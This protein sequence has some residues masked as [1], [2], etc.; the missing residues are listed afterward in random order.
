MKTLRTGQ[1]HRLSVIRQA[2]SHPG[3]L[4]YSGVQD[5]GWCGQSLACKM[6][7]QN[8]ELAKTPGH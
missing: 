7:L 5:T 3:I 4:L 8:S 2:P 6:K 1:E